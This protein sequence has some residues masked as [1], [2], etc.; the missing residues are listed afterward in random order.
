MIVLLA[1]SIAA[2]GADDSVSVIAGIDVAP[3]DHSS[4]ISALYIVHKC[5]YCCSRCNCHLIIRNSIQ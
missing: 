4:L 2:S 3:F 1:L 5:S